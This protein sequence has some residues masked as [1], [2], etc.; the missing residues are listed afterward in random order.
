MLMLKIKNIQD[1]VD[2]ANRILSPI[3]RL[4]GRELYLKIHEKMRREILYDNA[5]D[6][7]F[8]DWNDN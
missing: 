8:W 3:R 6:R 1:K 2:N 5:I 7:G 4:I